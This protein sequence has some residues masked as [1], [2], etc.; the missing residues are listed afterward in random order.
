MQTATNTT[1]QTTTAKFNQAINKLALSW[2]NPISFSYKE[3]DLV[4]AHPAAAKFMERLSQLGAEM[5]HFTN[6][7]GVQFNGYQVP[8]QFL[9]GLKIKNMDVKNMVV[10]KNTFLVQLDIT[11]DF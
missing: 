11:L 7:D 4:S 3:F 10:T 1:A 6:Q 8:D 2:K 9:S 5:Y